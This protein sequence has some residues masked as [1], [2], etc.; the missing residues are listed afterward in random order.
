M[1]S[2]GDVDGTSQKAFEKY[3]AALRGR[4]GEAKYTSWFLDLGLEQASKNA[5][6]LSTP[7]QTKCEILD[8]RFMH[9]MEDTWRREIGPVE[10]FSLT[11][12]KA[13]RA[14]VAAFKQ[15]EDNKNTAMPGDDLFAARKSDKSAGADKDSAHNG[16]KIDLAAPLDSRRTFGVLAV[17][18]SNRIA[19]AA[20]R[21]ATAEGQTRDVV[22]F[23]GDSGVGKTHL[24]Q[25]ICHSFEERGQAYLYVT[26]RNLTN[27]CV[28]AVLS[29]RTRD[30]HNEFQKYDVVAID[31]IHFLIGKERTQEELLI[32][33]DA[34]LDSGK[35]IVIAGDLAPTK[36]AGA[37]V[38]K[39]LADRLAGGLS[40]PV[41]AP[42][43]K[44]RLEILKK[45][46]ALS[47]A[48]C[49]ITDEAFEFIARNFASSARE[50]IGALNQLLLIYKSEPIT[51]DLAEVKDTLKAR[52]ADRVKVVT[53][54]DVIVAGAE[55][56]GLTTEDVLGRAQPQRIVRSR[57]AI[58]YCAR[59]KLRESFPRIGK[60]LGRD[61]T[62]VMSSHRRAQ[63]LIERDKAFQDGVARIYEALEG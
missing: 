46:F 34:L 29:N 51:I 12:R 16:A 57:H 37:G 28:S 63:A 5:V 4:V 50:A 33:V 42:D 32:V 47:D 53:M 20:A 24:L 27:A 2:L 55:A 49:T 40:A 31:D 61:H 25:S 10:K 54:T 3:L 18:D 8:D 14:S 30:L 17:G 35:Q 62:T 39:R 22:Y 48:R 58:V 56:F 21:Q 1:S 15:F 6:V 52:I 41:Y 45:R 9:V 7:T 60:A 23:H 59:E 43:E 19:E 44:M 26:Y 11:V 36:L 13:L 38:N